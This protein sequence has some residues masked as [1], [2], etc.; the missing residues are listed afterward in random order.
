MAYISNGV[1]CCKEAIVLTFLGIFLPIIFFLFNHTPSIP[2]SEDPIASKSNRS[3]IY[4]HL[5]KGILML[6]DIV[7]K[8]LESGF[9][10]LISPDTNTSEKYLSKPVLVNFNL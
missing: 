10:I 9:F 7:L 8:I 2:A 3:P 1:N 4:T 5:S 6:S